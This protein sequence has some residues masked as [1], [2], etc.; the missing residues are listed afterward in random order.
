M[1]EIGTPRSRAAAA[2]LI[3]RHRR[4]RG[5]RRTSRVEEPL[6]STDDRPFAGSCRTPGTTSSRGWI[7]LAE[8]LIR[9]PRSRCGRHCRH[10][11]IR[12]PTMLSTF[13]CSASG[14]DSA[15]APRG[16]ATCSRIHMRPVRPR[17]HR[18]AEHGAAAVDHDDD[19]RA[20]RR[21]RTAEGA[22]RAAAALRRDRASMGGISE[23]RGVRA[24]AEEVGETQRR[25]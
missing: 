23:R 21:V 15:G 17:H 12:R 19:D 25:G 4:R 13:F 5:E 20:R 1:T 6:K 16:A 9:P 14:C 24:I 2:A 7:F 18:V 8:G 22:S 11:T 10:R 3:P